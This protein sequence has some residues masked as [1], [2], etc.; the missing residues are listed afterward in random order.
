METLSGSSD[1]R[2]VLYGFKYVICKM[3]YL[4]IKW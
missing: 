4:A 3:C 1:D 2:N